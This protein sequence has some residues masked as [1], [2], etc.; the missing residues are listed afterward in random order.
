M[1]EMTKLAY[2]G[3]SMLLAYNILPLE[4]TNQGLKAEVLI[5]QDW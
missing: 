5:G 1:L 4:V 2:T 3:W